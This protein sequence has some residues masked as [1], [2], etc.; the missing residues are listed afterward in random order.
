M[1]YVFTKEI[2]IIEADGGFDIMHNGNFEGF[3]MT[4]EE[5]Y[6]TAQSLAEAIR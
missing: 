1:T 2:E 3:E 5:A 4:L 6:K